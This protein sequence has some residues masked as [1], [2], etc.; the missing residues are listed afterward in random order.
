MSREGYLSTRRKQECSEGLDGE[1]WKEASVFRKAGRLSY[2]VLLLL[3]TLY[4]SE[5]P[6]ISTNLLWT[7]DSRSLPLFAHCRSSTQG[8][9]R[10][11]KFAA[12][13]RC[14]AAAL[15]RFPLCNRCA[16]HFS[17]SDRRSTTRRWSGAG[18][19]PALR[20]ERPPH[21]PTGPAPP[22]L[23]PLGQERD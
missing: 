11:G 17:P 3:Y 16:T 18:G 10:C 21:R 5:P 19:L 7:T 23:S 6:L 2:R 9:W 12:G 8:L 22:C 13:K 14:T 15:I 1:L 4:V 20:H